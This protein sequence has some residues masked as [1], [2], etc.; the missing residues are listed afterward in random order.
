M[1]QAGFEAC[2]TLNN[3]GSGFLGSGGWGGGEGAG[4]G[5][6][7]LQPDI[8]HPPLNPPLGVWLGAACFLVE[9]GRI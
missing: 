3:L 4:R 2:A 6:P 5:G 1:P 8:T 7:G 9:R